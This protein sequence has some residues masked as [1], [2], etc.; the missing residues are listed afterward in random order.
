MVQLKTSTELLL[1]QNRFI[2]E[3]L[4]ALSVGKRNQKGTHL[5]T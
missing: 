3:S 1:K 4:F 2:K 5:K